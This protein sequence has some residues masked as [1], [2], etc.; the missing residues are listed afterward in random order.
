MHTREPLTREELK[1][2]WR[3]EQHMFRFHAV[4]LTILAVCAAAAFFYSDIAW[5]RRLL[6]V[7]VALLIVAAT[8]LQMREKCPRC[9]ARLRTNPVASLTLSTSAP[10]PES[11]VEYDNNATRGSMPNCRAVCADEI[12]MSASCSDVGS[13]TIAQSP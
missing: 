6:L 5:V 13:G 3:W 11:P 10:V 4:A 9:G 2:L 7:L 8:I 12:A 1:R